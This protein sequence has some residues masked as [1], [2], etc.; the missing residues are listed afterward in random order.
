MESSQSPTSTIGS[1]GRG[2]NLPKVVIV[3]SHPIQHFCPM[4]RDIAATGEVEL[5]VLFAEAGG[6][7]KFDKDFG[8]VIEWQKD[9]LEGVPYRRLSCTDENRSAEVVKALEEFGPDV[10]YV[11]GYSRPYLRAAMDWSGKRKI[12]ILMTTD[13]E[14]LHYRPPHVRFIKKLVLPGVLAKVRVFL[15][16]GDENERYYSYYGVPTGHMARVPFSIDSKY[17]DSILKSK[18]E[19][20]ASL[21]GSLGITEDKCAILTVGK[22]IPRK[23]QAELITAFGQLPSELRNRAVLLIA[24]D[25]PD[26]AELEK[27]AAPFGSAVR[28]LG[29]IGVDVL[30][31]YYIASDLY[32][33]PST[34]D[35]HPLAISEAA[36]CSLPIV[37]S[38]RIGSIGETD[39]VQVGRNGWVYKS[40]DPA[41]LKD[42]FA[43]LI[44]DQEARKSASIISRQLGMLH[45]SDHCARLFVDVVKTCSE[46]ATSNQKA[47]KW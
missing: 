25:G 36:Y 47:T 14:L 44:L 46:R 1:T 35:P 9:L 20:R 30:P 4:Y 42:I 10:V 2:A 17:Y 22:L 23:A 8:K 26:R 31:S 29:F 45:A 7:A 3:I 41:G 19:T 33:H 43:K 37:V 6:E 21:R 18:E 28:F 15:T 40:R 11:H 13:S 32:V 12:P 24:G 39:D 38:D 16:V 27:L 34:F 5:Q